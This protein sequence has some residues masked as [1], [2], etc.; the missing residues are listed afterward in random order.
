V[1]VLEEV[2]VVDEVLVRVLLGDELE[3]RVG[4][5]DRVPD[6]V[7]LI[8]GLPV[9]VADCVFVNGGD[10]V[11]VGV[12]VDVLDG[13]EERVREGEPLDVF[14]PPMDFVAVRVTGM[15]RDPLDVFVEQ[16]DAVLVFERAEEKL[17]LGDAVF[18]LDPRGVTEFVGEEE[19]VL[20]EVPEGEEVFV[21]VIVFVE[22]EV[23]VIVRD[24]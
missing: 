12:P 3:V 14:V 21:E 1:D 8:L 16:G 20:E 24:R 17:M 9:E 6:R 4:G 19:E 11:T 23:P 13:G 22:V 5:R 15:V 7:T 2:V 10:L 18:D